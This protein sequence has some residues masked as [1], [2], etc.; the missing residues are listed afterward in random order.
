[1]VPRKKSVLENKFFVFEDG[2]FI[3]SRKGFE[4]Y[5]NFGEGNKNKMKIEYS[6]GTEGNYP[7]ILD[8]VSRFNKQL[9]QTP[10][11]RPPAECLH[12]ARENGELVGT[13]GFDRYGDWIGEIRWLASAVPR[14]GVGKALLELSMQDAEDSRVKQVLAITDQANEE[15]FAGF[16]FDKS[17]DNCDARVKMRNGS[18]GHLPVDSKVHFAEDRDKDAIRRLIE[19]YPWLVVDENLRPPIKHYRV[20]EEQG[21]VTACGGLQVY[22]PKMAEIFSLAVQPG[23]ARRQYWEEQL[24]LSCLQLAERHNVY[25]VLNITHPSQKVVFERFGFS[26]YN[27]VK[28][29]LI[30]TLN[31]SNVAGRTAQQP[32]LQE[33]AK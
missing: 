23:H 10:L 4:H 12:L 8:F 26:V 16:G 6:R 27:E 32:T 19:L 25:Q 1:M 33:A 29:A 5:R 30:K 18:L 14:R 13:C 21:E 22:G 31:N 2:F 9:V 3:S 24:L 20:V 28:V 17:L 7:E 11:L 15:F